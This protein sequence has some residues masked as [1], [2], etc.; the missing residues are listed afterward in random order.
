MLGGRDE[1]CCILAKLVNFDK[2]FNVYPDKD[3]RLDGR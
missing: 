2:C 3:N 1:G